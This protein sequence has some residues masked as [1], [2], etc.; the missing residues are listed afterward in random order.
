MIENFKLFIK[1]KV[2]HCKKMKYKYKK[3]I[4]GPY[5]KKH[6]SLK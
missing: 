6:G 1:Q 3:L 5:Q 4:K 2:W